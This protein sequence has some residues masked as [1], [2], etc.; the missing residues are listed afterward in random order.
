MAIKMNLS[1]MLAK[2]GMTSKKL[3]DTI[4]TTTVNLSRIKNGVIRGMR[5]STLSEI[6]RVLDCQPGDILEY[7]PDE[8]E[9]EIHKTKRF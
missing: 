6:C 7:V 8:D 5:F 3:A 2:R 4:G 1:V 9:N